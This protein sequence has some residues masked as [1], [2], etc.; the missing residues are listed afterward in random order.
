MIDQHVLVTGA[1]RGLGEAVVHRFAELGWKISFGARNLG[2]IQSVKDSLVGIADSYFVESLDVS[3]HE[4]VSR[5]FDG[6]VERFG[7]PHTVVHSAG[8][9]G[10]FGPTATINAEAWTQTIQTNL[11]GTLFVL[12]KSLSLMEPIGRGNII[13]LSGGGATN[14]M[15]NI[16]A[17]AASKAGVV[18]L[19][20][21]VA[22]EV[23]DTEIIIS[24]VA[25]GL[26]ATKML[27]EIIDAGPMLV[28]GDFYERMTIAKQNNENSL[29]DAVQLIEFLA[30][31][32]IPQLSGRLISAK[33]DPWREW[34]DD[35]S[36]LD[37]QSAFTLR[38][39][40]PSETSNTGESLK[41]RS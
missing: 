37:D 3:V 24:A 18:R 8:I 20:E 25:P 38:R 13:V 36:V 5:F 15:P 28:G 2:A 33:W 27:D 12:Q 17:Y 7:V 11:I 29:S 14:P 23:S 19:V 26:M 22:Q 31:N 21:S 35:P 16:S 32:Q 4:S 9:Y 1:S 30:S 41:I 39:Q 40:V 6:A 10:P 34:I